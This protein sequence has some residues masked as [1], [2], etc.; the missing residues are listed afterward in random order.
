ME[1]IKK[2]L[3]EN[4]AF[5][6]FSSP[7]LEQI[8]SKSYVK[9]L[10]PNDY[11]I[12]Q[13][14]VTNDEFYLILDGVMEAV[15]ETKD[16]IYPLDILNPGSIVGENVLLGSKE[17]KASIVA[18][19][20]A[21]VLVITKKLVHQITKENFQEGIAFFEKAHGQ[22]LLYLEN[23]NQKMIGLVKKQKNMGFF[24]IN[25]VSVLS[26]FSVIVPYLQKLVKD[27]PATYV[28]SSLITVFTVLLLV[29]LHYTKTPMSSI[30]ITKI[31]L[32]KSIVDALIISPVF[33]LVV[34]FVKYLLIHF[35]PAFHDSKLFYNLKDAS[36]KKFGVPLSNMK[37]MLFACTYS[38]FA[39]FQ[40]ILARGSLQ[41]NFREFILFKYRN[42]GAILLSNL[43]FAC[44]HATYGL[45]PVLLV[46]FPGLFWG[47]LYYRSGN[48][49]GVALSHALIGSIFI[50]FIG[51]L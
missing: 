49:F 50:I 37:L 8:A 43:I 30:G 5:L 1:D 47:W 26:I 2:K 10:A 20:S 18:R 35:V 19:T 45:I 48:I 31:N 32:K 38:I 41:G 21:T 7:L 36:F 6:V 27:I 44:A 23:I 17:R 12:K 33:I 13:G 25:L 39:F 11:L 3:E 40:E 46:F 22:T 24:I 4:P 34:I 9:T 42:V 51:V 15:F 29:R 14:K 16:D 28:S